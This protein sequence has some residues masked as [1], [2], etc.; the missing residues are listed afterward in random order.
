M[1]KTFTAVAPCR[2][3]NL[4]PPVIIPLAQLPEHHA[5]NLHNFHQA[6][7]LGIFSELP[8]KM[9]KQHNPSPPSQFSE[10]TIRLRSYLYLPAE[11]HIEPPGQMTIDE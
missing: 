10:L 8:I 7:N 9:P 5:W 4:C 6:S 11:I 1:T 2:C 3:K